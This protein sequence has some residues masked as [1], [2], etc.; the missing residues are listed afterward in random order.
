M[1]SNR[2]LLTTYEEYIRHFLD[3]ILSKRDTV[4]TSVTDDKDYDF[5]L[6]IV[7]SAD[8]PIYVR[9]KAEDDQELQR[10]KKALKSGE[11]ISL[12]PDKI[13][14]IKITM[15]QPRDIETP[16]GSFL[17]LCSLY[18][19]TYLLIFR[20][21]APVGATLSESDLSFF[22]DSIIVNPSKADI[23]SLLMEE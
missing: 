1:A 18:D 9:I 21:I 2:M 6:T 16:E 3:V 17:R 7:Q 5:Y 13:D 8:T 22:V 14:A 23:V 19:N 20:F 4:K 10:I 15:K 11:D 12:P